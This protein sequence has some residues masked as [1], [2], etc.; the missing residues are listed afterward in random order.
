MHEFGSVLWPELAQE[1]VQCCMK[2]D[3]DQ[4][5]DNAQLHNSLDHFK[6]AEQFEEA[7]AQLL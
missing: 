2:P 6:T 3:Q 5:K 7:A 1:Y 4:F